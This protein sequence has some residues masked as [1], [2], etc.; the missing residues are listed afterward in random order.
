M[1]ASQFAQVSDEEI[2]DMKMKKMSS[3]FFNSEI[4]LKQLYMPQAQ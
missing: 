2:S 1:A 3:L 4:I